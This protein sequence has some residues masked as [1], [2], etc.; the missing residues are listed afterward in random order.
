MNEEI[1][2]PAR[3]TGETFYNEILPLLYEKLITCKGTFFFDLSNTTFADPE[4]IVNFFCI[5]AITKLKTGEIPKLILPKDINILK[6]FENYKFFS[7]AKTPGSEILD[8]VKFQNYPEYKEKPITK[9]SGI[10]SYSNNVDLRQNIESLLKLIDKYFILNVNEFKYMEFA[11]FQTIRNIIEHNF[12]NNPILSCG[13][14]MAQRT[15]KNSFE[16]V[17]SDY[18]KGYRRRII[19]MI[20]DDIDGNIGYFKQFSKYILDD[21]Y[22]FENSRRNPNF[23]AIQAALNF[24]KDYQA[25]P[26]LYQIME[27]VSSLG[28]QFSLHSENI[29]VTFLNPEKYKFCYYDTFFNGCHIKIDIP[30]VSKIQVYEVR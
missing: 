2:F 27:F 22:L 4:G 17:I 19:E 18:G 11:L 8:F 28:G 3:L 12:E 13:Y 10:F 30:L 6:F 26:G 23:I 7:V 24:R 25:K 21:S 20:K 5:S 15:P 14:L 29:K 1:S 9:I 16:F